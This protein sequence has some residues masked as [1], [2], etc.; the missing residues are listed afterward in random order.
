MESLLTLAH[1]Y[2]ARKGTKVLSHR[3]DGDQI[4]F[5]LESGP[6][7]TMTS[8]ELQQVL[9]P[10]PKQVTSPTTPENPESLVLINTADGIDSA[11]ASAA[12]KALASTRKPRKP[13]PSLQARET[14]KRSS[15]S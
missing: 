5:I 14:E 9:T 15:K 4:T 1:Q 13:S 12:G 6:K 2:A 3:L 11:E 8:V 10:D 7:L